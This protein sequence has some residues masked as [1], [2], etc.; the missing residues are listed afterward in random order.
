MKLYPVAIRC[1]YMGAINQAVA[2]STCPMLLSQPVLAY[3]DAGL[4]MGRNEITRNTFQVAVLFADDNVLVIG[5]L[6]VAVP[7]LIKQEW[8]NIP[9][10]YKRLDEG[11]WRALAPEA[12]S[13]A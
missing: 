8:S 9:C 6:D 7:S 13:D 12:P 10:K 2:S 11:P 5:N 3:W 1:V 4:R